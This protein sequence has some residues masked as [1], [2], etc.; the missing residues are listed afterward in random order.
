MR[1]ATV[2]HPLPLPCCQ[3]FPRW[4]NSRA[5]AV[6]Q[7]SDHNLPFEFMRYHFLV[8]FISAEACRNASRCRDLALCL[9]SG[10]NLL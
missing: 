7:G 9:A 8:G 1:T 10:I 5:V 2:F 3:R 4:P 6:G